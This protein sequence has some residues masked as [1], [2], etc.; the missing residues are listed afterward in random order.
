M[1]NV[2]WPK[3]QNHPLTTNDQAKLDRSLRETES[4]TFKPVVCLMCKTVLFYAADNMDGYIAVKCQKC[5]AIIPVNPAY[6][7]SSA[8]MA[9]I[10]KRNEFI[11]PLEEYKN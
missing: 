1:F 6:F 4:L 11:I 3:T 10:R 8:Y 7:K 9:I 2:R 5:K